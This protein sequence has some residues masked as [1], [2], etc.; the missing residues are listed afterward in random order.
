MTRPGQLETG[1]V[2][3]VSQLNAFLKS[4][5]GRKALMAV[6][7]LLLIGFLVMHVSANLLLLFDH[8]AFNAYSHKLI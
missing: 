3:A 5:I 1:G 2:D 8:E 4:S 6:T 7:G